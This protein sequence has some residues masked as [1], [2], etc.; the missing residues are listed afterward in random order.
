LTNIALNSTKFLKGKRTKGNEE[1]R[2]LIKKE[3]KLKALRRIFAV[4]DC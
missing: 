3:V 2:T 1:K 4:V